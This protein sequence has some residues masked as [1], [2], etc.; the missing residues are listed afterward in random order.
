M[1]ASFLAKAK[2]L[3]LAA[4]RRLGRLSRS[5]ARA[6]LVVGAVTTLLV[7]LDAL[8]LGDHQRPGR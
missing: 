4:M 5:A 7:V 2:S 1:R 6:A 8:L 3:A